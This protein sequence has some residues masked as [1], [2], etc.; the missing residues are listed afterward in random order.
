IFSRDWSSDVCSSVLY[1][2]EAAGRRVPGMNDVL[3]LPGLANSWTMPIRTRIDML[4]TG[5]RTPIGIKV[6]GPDLPTLS[7]LADEIALALR[8]EERRV[9]THH[10]WRC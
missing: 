6:L 2:Y 1:G 9:G 3:Q 8:S 10:K 4:A 7:R 5:I